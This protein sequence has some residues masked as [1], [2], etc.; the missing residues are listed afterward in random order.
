[1]KEFGLIGRNISYSF[2]EKYFAEKFQKENISDS[3][4]QIFDLDS[5]EEVEQL[6]R[7]PNLIGLNV[8]IPY[9][10][11]IL[12]YL[13]ELD[14]VAQE[15]GAVNCVKII[16]GRRIGFNTDAYGFEKSLEPLLEFCHQDALILGDGG[17]A[18]AVKFCLNKHLINFKTVTRQG[19]LKFSDLTDELISNHLLIINCTPI[20]TF[21]KVDAYPDIPYNSISSQHL[22]YDLIYNPDKTEFLKR[23]EK[24]GAKIKNGLEMLILQAEKSWEI[25]NS[26]L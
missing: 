12:P 13:D 21:P 15:I 17:A 23:G 16:N 5:I 14:H 6:F 3:T 18:K 22:L 26:S 8:T 25:W 4:Y 2:S 24:K 9:K 11:A 1:M 10:E 7:N 20:G 19:D